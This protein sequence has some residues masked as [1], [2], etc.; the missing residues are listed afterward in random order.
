M[1]DNI[2]GLNPIEKKTSISNNG[3]IHSWRICPYCEW[4]MEE[5]NPQDLLLQK[6]I[7][8]DILNLKCQCFRS[9]EQ[10]KDQLESVGFK[11][12]YF[13]PDTPNLFPTVTAIKR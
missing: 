1:T 4:N 8:A 13:I 9:T 5:I 10:T 3:K 12:I 6:I 2:T 11:D 7:F